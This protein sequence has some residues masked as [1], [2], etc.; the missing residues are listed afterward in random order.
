MPIGSHNTFIGLLF[1]KGIIGLLLYVVPL[2]LTTVYLFF[3]SFI[4]RDYL[5]GF[6]VILIFLMYS[7][8]EN[9]EIL[10]YLMWPGWLFIGMSLRACSYRCDLNAIDFEDNGQAFVVRK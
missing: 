1:I 8:T 3:K 4:R 10:S 7:F 2:I 5:A 9:I 6:F